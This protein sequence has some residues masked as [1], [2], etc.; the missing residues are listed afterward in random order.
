MISQYVGHHPFNRLTI[1]VAAPEKQGVYYC[2]SLN[3]DG[4]LGVYYVG[5]AKGTGVSIRSRLLDHLNTDHWT[6]VT[7]FGFRL[8]STDQEATDFEASEIRRLQPAYNTVGK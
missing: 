5:R 6:A 4:S 1:C 3:S 7:H 8:C 2:G